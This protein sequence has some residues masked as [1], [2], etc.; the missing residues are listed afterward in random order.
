MQNNT[1]N[2]VTV[3]NWGQQVDE[4]ADQ[5][6]MLALNLALNLARSKDEISELTVLEP[7]F[8][9]LVNGSV[10][11]IK[12]VTT[13]L[14]AFRNEEKMVYSPNSGNLKLD[15]I[16][17]SLNEILTLSKN[18]LDSINKIKKQ[19]DQVDKYKQD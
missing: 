1:E 14:R 2:K 15:R 9:K 10:D 4:L 8:T 17:T 13:I 16:E 12:E 5:V 19:K 3:E 6:K 18:V 7:E 11:V